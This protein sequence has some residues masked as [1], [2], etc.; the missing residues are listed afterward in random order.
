MSSTVMNSRPVEL[1]AGFAAAVDDVV[2]DGDVVDV[3]R[4]DPVAAGAADVEAL[5][6]DVAVPDVNP[7]PGA[8]RRP[9]QGFAGNFRTERDVAGGRAA[10][11][12]RD[13]F[14]VGPGFDHNLVARLK[15]GLHGVTDRPPGI[16]LA[17]IGIVGS[18]RGNIVRS[19]LFSSLILG[20]LKHQNPSHGRKSVLLL[21][22]GLIA[23]GAAYRP[24]GTA[25]RRP[26]PPSCV[27]RGMPPEPRR[28]LSG[29]TGL[30]G[31][32]DARGRFSPPV[33]RDRADVKSG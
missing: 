7:V 11:I 10:V 3:V 4:L 6:G 17:A 29:F 32:G 20:E 13:G 24:A 8:F 21:S 9:D 28:G 33:S 12:D 15:V 1:D 26:A 5:D 27:I 23:R 22:P 19:H 31:A 14:V 25:T 18:R 16:R 30:S 2:A